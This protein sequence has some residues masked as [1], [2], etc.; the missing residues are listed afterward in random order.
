MRVDS[1]NS[2][3]NGPFFVIPFSCPI[4]YNRKFTIDL[5]NARHFQQK[6]LEHV[7]EGV[8]HRCGTTVFFYP[9][10]LKRRKTPFF[11]MFY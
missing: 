8:K 6:I 5:L 11:T 1:I 9:C 3:E 7:A 2:R 4:L 10:C